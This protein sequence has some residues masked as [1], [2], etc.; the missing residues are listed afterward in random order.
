MV[1]LEQEQEI[2]LKSDKQEALYSKLLE[3]STFTKTERDLLIK[4]YLGKVETS[5]DAS[6]LIDK[7]ICDIRAFKYFIGKRKHRVAQCSVC[8]E[9]IDLKRFLEIKTNKKL[10]L[11]YTHRKDAD[12]SEFAEVPRKQKQKKSVTTAIT[13]INKVL[14]GLDEKGEL[15]SVET[16]EPE[17]GMFK[18]LSVENDRR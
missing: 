3:S 12:P 16:D 15:V 8:S 10:W 11:C 4:K 7:L 14:V 5:Y 2:Q 17:P 18:V 1:I 9:K 13:P 6:V